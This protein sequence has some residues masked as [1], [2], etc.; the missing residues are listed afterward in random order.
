MTTS[1][2]WPCTRRRRVSPTCWS[3]TSVT[4]TSRCTDYPTGKPA[5]TFAI[6]GLSE[7]EGLAL[8]ATETGALL[9]VADE[10]PGD[11]GSDIKLVDFAAIT[12]TLELQKPSDLAAA[13]APAVV[14]ATRET[15]VIPTWGDSADDP[16]IWVHPDD[17]TQSLVIG[18]GKK[19]G[20]Y[21]FDLEGRTLQVLEDGRMNNVDL[22]DG[23]PLGGESVSI[24][25]A[26]NRSN[27]G[28]SLYRIDGDARELVDVADGVL[29]TGFADPYGL[30]LYQSP[31][32][33]DFFVFVN[34]SG[35]G[36]VRQW[37]LAD[38]GAG[39][40]AA[41]AVRDLAVGSQAEGCVADDQ[42]GTLYIAEEDIGLWKYSAEP[43]GGDERTSIDT[44]N[45][46]GRLTADVE[47]VA[48]Y[49]AGDGS[50][51][52]VVSNQGANNYAVYR[53][54]GENAFVGF[55][56]IVANAAEGIDG[57][58]ETDGLDV[59]PAALGEAFPDGLL[60]VQDGRNI[61]PEERQNFKYVSWS[62]VVTRTRPR[63]SGLG[64][65]C[66]MT[67]GSGRGRA[68]NRNTP[69]RAS[70]TPVSARR[71]SRGCVRP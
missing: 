42:N 70:K 39:R 1:R 14:R 17:P 32:S 30:C 27:D 12:V 54:E 28:I 22:R 23:F 24:V 16:A 34:D 4:N 46:S 62:D 49:D 59:S 20:L 51:Y 15:D 13:Q 36:M 40:I 11:G 25:A 55:F 5:G 7:P 35:S 57:A 38:N 3:P 58:S 69:A 8:F 2:V 9:A 48:L 37:R 64:A 31:D 45:E 18:T 53:R 47:G 29:A 52:L 60:V 65:T 71:C 26:S 67:I 68:Q 61:A 10:D 63:L 6:E 56:H 33:R 41:E 50:G 66:G 44:T 21:V 19:S 43:D